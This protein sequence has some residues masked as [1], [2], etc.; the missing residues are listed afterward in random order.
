VND[1]EILREF[2]QKVWRAYENTLVVEHFA[3]EKV[4][5]GCWLVTARLVRSMRDPIRLIFGKRTRTYSHRLLLQIQNHLEVGSLKR[6][7]PRYTFVELFQLI[8][9]QCGNVNV[10]YAQNI[11]GVVR[12]I[13]RAIS[14]C[15]L[16]DVNR[17]GEVDPSGGGADISCLRY[18]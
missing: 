10:G 13:R 3:F 5:G 6:M 17:P 18:Q 2:F 14:G 16:M 8:G 7:S 15:Q 12:M 11:L 9:R 1:W 4:L